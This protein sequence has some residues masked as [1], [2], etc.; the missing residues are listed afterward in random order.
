[1][2]LSAQ[3][4]NTGDTSDE[5]LNFQELV[6][7]DK[8]KELSHNLFQFTK[9]PM[10]ILD[11]QKEVLIQEGWVDM[12]TIYHRNN[13]ASLK[14]CLESDT[15][16]FNSVNKD[17]LIEYKCRNG[18]WDIALPI[19]IEDKII[20]AVFIGQF[21]YEDDPV[22]IERFKKQAE[23][24]G[25]EK[26]AYLD[27]FQ[28]VPRVSKEKVKQIISF[29]T[30][31]AQQIADMGYQKL[32]ILRLKE[33][34]ISE[35]KSIIK[36]KNKELIQANEELVSLN[37]ELRVINEELSSSYNELET[38]NQK[39]FDN[40]SF[41]DRV[42]DD[43]PDAM[44]VSDKNGV[45]IKTNK[46]LREMR[47][48]S[49]DKHIGEYNIKDDK[50]VKSK[51]LLPLVN[52]VYDEGK[53]VDFIVEYNVNDL[54]SL[55]IKNLS[56]IALHTYIT[57]LFNSNGEVVNVICQ[58]R[59]I[60][61]LK[62]K[63]K[64]IQESERKYKKL[65]ELAG[66][67]AF[68]LHNDIFVD[69]NERTL[70][71]FKLSRDELLGKH[72]WDLSPEFQ[73]NGLSSMSFA[74][75][76]ISKVQQ[77]ELKQFE[78]VHQKGNGESFYADIT[79]S[80]ID[81]ESQ[82]YYAVIHDM[83]SK[84]QAK[85]AL[86]QSEGMLRSVIESS[87]VGIVVSTKDWINLSFNKKLTTLTGYTVELCPTANDWF[88]MAFPK[89]EYR[90]KVMNDWMKAIDSYEKTGVF[91]TFE[92]KVTCLNGSL[93][94]IEF[95]FNT[96]N[97]LNISTCVDITD[98]N[99]A[100]QL[101]AES[102]RQLLEAEELAKL[103]YFKL[104]LKEDWWEC[105]EVLEK[106]LGIDYTYKKNLSG[107]LR[108]IHPDFVEGFNVSLKAFFQKKE[109]ID[110]EYKIIKYDTKEEVW[111]HGLGSPVLDD[112]GAIELMFGT[113]QDITE[114]K[115]AEEAL[116]KANEELR[117]A[118]ATKDRLFSV[119]GHDLMSPFTAIQGY[120]EL[121][122]EHSEEINDSTLI[123]YAGILINSESRVVELLNNLLAWSRIQSNTA[124]LDKEEISL[125]EL[126]ENMVN[127]FEASLTNKSIQLKNS[128]DKEQIISVDEKMIST[129][130]RNLISNAV[131]FTP[132]RGAIEIASK[133]QEG[134]VV[135]S[136]TDNGV[137]IPEEKI[138]L[139]FDMDSDYSSHG[140]H[141]ELG[142]GLGLVLCKE[143]VELHKGKL[144][145]DS[146]VGKGSKF[147]FS[148]PCK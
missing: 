70:D 25:F 140:T 94:D 80:L 133:E 123:K 84:K 148:L 18:L 24:Y 21:L 125:F 119:I 42:I 127:L 142:T 115:N 86:Q 122:K 144:G 111:L 29:Y 14:K 27:A 41:L 45:I 77:G 97:D 99:K 136:V 146:E 26:K 32:Q 35:K 129:V 89:E 13:E 93:K 60:T 49:G 113:I 85:L 124:Q 63:E 109:K 87:P 11:H 2:S 112:N 54:E 81:K 65:F 39:L 88:S 76:I 131:K 82:I 101:L 44:W 38:V 5:R 68:V 132:S 47:E 58:H 134:Y 116:L 121:I 102:E 103:G 90:N 139:L 73:K 147:T 8:L 78:W 71:L 64:C 117:M 83:T 57:P 104:Y 19:V 4:K 17:K 114:R 37:E 128:V 7:L 130:L 59:N 120:T 48:I 67:G 106:I 34:E 16:I 91:P 105:S 145:V 135:I 10:A 9:L 1:M 66:D 69:C 79:L 52:K 28:R 20:A 43:S 110:D 46:A 12:C 6:D 61:E 22:E 51:G 95:G 15:Y 137:G 143:F 53:A 75:E 108:L 56:Y 23:V 141:K 31:F 107:F 40:T 118:N 3:N 72:P 33:K 100:L 50:I 96:V 138:P 92:A 30:A 98:R 74:K 55:G 126:A 36:Q 62:I